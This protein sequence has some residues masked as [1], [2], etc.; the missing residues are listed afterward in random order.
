MNNCLRKAQEGSSNT[1]N[2]KKKEGN[3]RN[4]ENRE[5]KEGTK[6]IAKTELE[7][8]ISC[9]HYNRTL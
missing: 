1:S 5:S 7:L 3:M 2:K 6:P 4:Q 9:V 8:I